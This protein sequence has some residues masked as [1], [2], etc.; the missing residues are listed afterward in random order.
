MI[1]LLRSLCLVLISAPAL[2]GAERPNVILIMTDD[3]GYGDL[4]CHGNEQIKTPHLDQ[5][6]GESVRLTDYHVDPTCSP[7]RAALMT[8][9]YSTRTG[10]WHTIMGRSIMHRDE[11]TLGDVFS[12]GGY[13]TG[14]FGKWHLGENYPYRP[15]DR[16]FDE[17]VI[18]GGGGVG[19]TPDY[20]E[21]KTMIRI[22]FCDA[23]TRCSSTSC[24]PATVSRRPPRR[25]LPGTGCAC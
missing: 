12:D 5:L 14:C 2:L 6:H 22:P 23:P 9:R 20:W 24:W 10:V 17:V 7:T 13:A 25:L 11:K 15:Q 8:G 19:Q 21:D 3:Q 4:A 1:R 16:G 18:H